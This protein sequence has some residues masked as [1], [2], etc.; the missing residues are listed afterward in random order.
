MCTIKTKTM[1]ESCR[2]NNGLFHVHVQ[3][4]PALLMMLILIIVVMDIDFHSV[5]KMMGVAYYKMAGVL[6][7]VMISITLITEHL[8]P[9]TTEVQVI[10]SC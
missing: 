5:D 7:A 10:I 9:W 4:V 2:S 3:T 1:N 6:A 8:V